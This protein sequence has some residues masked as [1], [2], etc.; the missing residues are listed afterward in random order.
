MRRQSWLWIGVVI[1]LMTAPAQAQ[2]ANLFVCGAP[3]I[4]GSPSIL[5]LGGVDVSECSEVVGL[6]SGV[7]VSIIDGRA[8]QP[9]CDQVELLKPLDSASPTY[10]SLAFQRT[11]VQ[12]IDI[13][14]FGPNPETGETELLYELSLRQSNVVGVAQ[15]VVDGPVSERVTLAPTR[16]VAT[17]QETGGV[18]DIRCDGRV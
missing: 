2:H 17:F 1:G 18:A 10:L 9:T 15:E 14:V 3:D 5:Q 13:L 7:E 6:S 8:G 11:R 12:R 16:I 4:I